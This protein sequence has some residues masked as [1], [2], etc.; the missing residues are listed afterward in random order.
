[1]PRPSAIRRFIDYPGRE[2]P[3]S[4]A[5]TAAK[6]RGST[7]GWEQPNEIVSASWKH[8]EWSPIDMEKPAVTPARDSEQNHG[9][10]LYFYFIK[11]YLPF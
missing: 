2:Y 8:E 1:M 3:S 7:L 10:Q 4:H 9:L 6:A 11:F 5:A